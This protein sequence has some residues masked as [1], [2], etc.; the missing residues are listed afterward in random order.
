M[1]R[2]IKRLMLQE[3]QTRYREMPQTGCVLVNYRG[4][5]AADAI[6]VRRAV[7]ANGGQMSVV[8]NSLFG[9]AMQQVGAG[10]LAGALDGPTAVITA[11]NPVDAAKV[12]RRAAEMCEG[13]TIYGA[14]VDGTMV[15]AGGVAKLADTPSR[16]QLLSMIAGALMA[17]LR[18]LLNGLLAKPRELVS[19][20]DQLKEKKQ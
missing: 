1:A 2:E 3:L 6:A 13:I 8:R 15:D 5:R 12:A 9:L 18:R 20:L 17:P 4:M 16:E 10:S 19:C 14:Y 7:G 11:G